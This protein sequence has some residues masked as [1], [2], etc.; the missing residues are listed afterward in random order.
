MDFADKIEIERIEEEIRR[1]STVLSAPQRKGYDAE[2]ESQTKNQSISDDFQ[3][4]LDE[5]EQTFWL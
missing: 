1:Q 4:N 5:A 2:R 3:P